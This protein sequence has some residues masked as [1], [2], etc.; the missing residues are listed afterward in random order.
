[1]NKNKTKKN[2]YKRFVCR[3]AWPQRRSPP[4]PELCYRQ[5]KHPTPPEDP[6][7]ETLVRTAD[8]PTDCRHEQNF[9]SPAE[10]SEQARRGHT[11]MP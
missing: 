11:Y 6:E 9:L 7:V 4:D 5:T 3:A 10:D 2:P 1:M 8:E